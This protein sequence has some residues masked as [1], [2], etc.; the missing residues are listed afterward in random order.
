MQVLAETAGVSKAYVSQITGG[1]R[2]G[3]VATLKRLATVLNAPLDALQPQDPYSLVSLAARLRGANGS[4][5][6]K[7]HGVACSSKGAG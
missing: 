3:T 7:R 2:A 5:Y 1:K 4:L 6:S